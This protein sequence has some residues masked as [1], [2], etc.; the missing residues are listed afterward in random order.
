MKNIDG[1]T[2]LIPFFNSARTITRTLDALMLQDIRRPVEIILLDSNSTDSSRSLIEKHPICKQWPVRIETVDQGGPGAKIN[3]GVSI[4]KYG[5]ILYTHSDCYVEDPSATEQMITF[6]EDPDVVGVASR[7]TLPI[8]VWRRM[9]FLDRV[10][11]SRYV[12]QKNYGFG[13]KYDI[14]RKSAFESIGGF[15]CE[16]FFSAGEDIDL[17]LRLQEIGRIVKSQVCVIHGH[18]SPVKP[19]LSSFFRKQAQLAQGF[20]A[21]NRKHL[22]VLRSGKLVS[23]ATYIHLLKALLLLGLFIPMTSIYSALLLLAMGTYYSWRAMLCFDWRII[24]VPFL[25][26]AAFVVFV[27]NAII[28]F[29]TGS[30]TTDYHPK[31]RSK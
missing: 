10:S 29:F 9:A 4:S 7:F 1:L 11:A 6:L 5:I 20:G 24:T 8:D 14:I 16:H 25:N 22:R 2:I 28:G 27:A 17:T 26:V 13:G 3:K 19:K 18:E 31:R 15:D 12:N 21:V 30:Q 23:R